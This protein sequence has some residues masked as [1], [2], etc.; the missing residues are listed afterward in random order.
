LPQRDEK[1]DVISWQLSDDGLPKPREVM[2]TLP[3]HQVRLSVVVPVNSQIIKQQDIGL[4][5]EW[6][7]VTRQAFTN[8]FANGWVVADFRRGS[9]AV[10]EYMLYRQ[11]DLNLPQAPWDKGE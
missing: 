7:Q 6:R 1:I 11:S 3:G 8:C 5:K 4:A 10:H 2:N 9:Q